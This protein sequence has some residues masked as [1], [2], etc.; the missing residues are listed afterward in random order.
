MGF[1]FYNGASHPETCLIKYDAVSILHGM[2]FLL[3]FSM[4]YESWFFFCIWTELLLL[5]VNYVL[6]LIDSGLLLVKTGA[7][8]ALTIGGM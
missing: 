5:F 3:V 2:V 4:S 7:S 6:L 8:S 1:H